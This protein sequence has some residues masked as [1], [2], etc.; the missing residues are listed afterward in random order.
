VAYLIKALSTTPAAPV[1]HALEEIV[2]RFQD[3]EFAKLA[4]KTLQGFGAILRP[5]DAPAT[6]LSGDLELFGL[7]NLLQTLAESH[8]TGALSLMDVEGESIGVL[9]LEDGMFRNCQVGILRGDEPSTSSS[10]L[11]P[12]TALRTAA[13]VHDSERIRAAL[14]DVPPAVLE[15]P[16]LRRIPQGARAVPV[17][18][19]PTASADAPSMNPTSGSAG[20]LTRI[21]SARP[22]GLRAA[23]SQD[24]PPL[25]LARDR[26]SRFHLAA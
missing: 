17:K 22:R 21:T 8:V 3:Q 2:K 1:R 20:A 6:T 15:A 13:T 25:A 26:R 5:P 11:V 18:P 12:G 7:P 24:P 14:G 9:H 23:D 4:E 19:S 10:E 16:P